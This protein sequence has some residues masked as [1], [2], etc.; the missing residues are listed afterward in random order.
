MSPDELREWRRAA[1]LTQAEL[2]ELLDM[3]LRAV[4]DLES[5]KTPLRRLH[6]LAIDSASAL[7]AI[8]ENDLTKATKGARRQAS[9][10]WLLLHGKDPA[11]D[12]GDKSLDD[13]E[14]Q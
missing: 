9:G 14:P 7:L 13:S 8:R 11:G 5:G 1:D 2:A 10:Y 6:V 3:S 12:L 4:Q